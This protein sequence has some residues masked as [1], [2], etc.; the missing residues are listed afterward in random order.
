MKTIKKK[1]Q[2]LFRRCSRDSCKTSL[3]NV[4]NRKGVYSQAE[5]STLS[6]IYI[7]FLTQLS[8]H[9]SK[10]L[11]LCYQSTRLHIAAA[12]REPPERRP[13]VSRFQ[14]NLSSTLEKAQAKHEETSQGCMFHLACNTFAMTMSGI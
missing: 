5:R 7:A 12:M 10:L 8:A 1:I 6:Y 9:E 4:M 3:N 2:N 14:S 13:H 11:Y